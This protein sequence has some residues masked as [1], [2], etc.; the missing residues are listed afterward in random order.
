MAAF[1]TDKMRKDD[2]HIL[3]S[4][5]LPPLSLNRFPPE[6]QN[7]ILTNIAALPKHH[8][9]DMMITCL[10]MY[11]RFGAILYHSLDVDENNVELVVKGLIVGEKSGNQ[12]LEMRDKHVNSV[13][14]AIA[15]KDQITA[16]RRK[17]KTLNFVQQIHVEDITAAA[18]LTKVKNWRSLEW[19]KKTDTL[20][21]IQRISLGAALVDMTRIVHM[22]FIDATKPSQ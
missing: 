2:S 11:H 13:D 8:L 22:L 10:Q 6:I 18:Q 1:T 17:L 15:S 16:H 4:P 14:F 7:M 3:S 21:N 5:N 12:P 9:V 19:D 20:V